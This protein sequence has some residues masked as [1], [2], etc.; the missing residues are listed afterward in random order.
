MAAGRDKMGQWLHDCMQCL[1]VRSLGQQ[2][3]Q[4]QQEH[5]VTQLAAQQQS[6]QHMQAQQELGVEKEEV[7]R[8]RL[9]V[10]A[11]RAQLAEQQATHAE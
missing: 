2:L 7:R 1:Q 11:L 4:Q 5:A 10:E 9:E 8:A 6:A 3:E